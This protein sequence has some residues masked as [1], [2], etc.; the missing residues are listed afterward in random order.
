MLGVAGPDC[1]VAIV[2]FFVVRRFVA[3]WVL[4]SLW[5]QH[6]SSHGRC[7][8][9]RCDHRKNSDLQKGNASRQANGLPLTSEEPLYLVKH[10]WIAGD[11]N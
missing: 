1:F 8:F 3:A 9:C 6:E 11:I 10:R 7:A 2:K 5:L 4:I